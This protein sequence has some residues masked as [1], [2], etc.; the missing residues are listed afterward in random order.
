VNQLTFWCVIV[1]SLGAISGIAAGFRRYTGLRSAALAG[2]V[3][4]GLTSFATATFF[5]ARVVANHGIHP[6]IFLVGL[7]LIL[8]SVPVGGIAGSIVGL[9]TANIRQRFEGRSRYQF[10]LETALFVLTVA[11]IALGLAYQF[12]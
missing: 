1:V 7:L 8:L 12:R 10:S 5:I 4:G 11:S 2:F 6:V 3:F 9:I